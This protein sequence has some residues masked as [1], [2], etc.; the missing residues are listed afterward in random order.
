[1]SNVWALGK[2]VVITMSQ[3]RFNQWEQVLQTTLIVSDRLNAVFFDLY[4]LYMLHYLLMPWFNLVI[5][6]MNILSMST[7]AQIAL[8]PEADR[9]HHA[10]ELS[11]EST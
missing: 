10:R 1:M 2:E 11:L 4:F 7:H 6:L 5:L 9:E 8:L 3:L